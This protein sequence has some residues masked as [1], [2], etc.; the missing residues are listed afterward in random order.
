MEWHSIRGKIMAYD[1]PR[2]LVLLSTQ[3]ASS[4]AS[5]VFT[6]FSSHFTTYYVSLRNI[7]PATNAVSLYVT[8]STDGGTTYLSA[9]YRYEFEEIASNTNAI[10]GSTSAAQGVLAQTVS[11]TASTGICGDYYLIDMETAVSF[12]MRG[13]CHHENSNSH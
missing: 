11:S 9:N 6:Q 5:L 12:N 10:T 3:T 13:M 2:N 4:S 8:F 7:L 1:Y